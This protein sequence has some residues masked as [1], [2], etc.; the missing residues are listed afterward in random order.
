M[1]FKV[2]NISFAGSE[3][4][5]NI[6]FAICMQKKI[7]LD[8]LF[9]RKDIKLHHNVDD[10]ARKIVYFGYVP[11]SWRS[12]WK[13]YKEYSRVVAPV[14]D[15]S[16]SYRV[17]TWSLTDPL[18]RY[19]INFF[20]VKDIYYFEEGSGSYRKYGPYNYNL[21]IKTFFVSTFIFLS[22]QV[23]SLTIKPLR[24]SWIKGWALFDNCFPDIDI[25]KK[26]IEHKCFQKVVED[27]LE[28]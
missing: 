12:I 9:I 22:T 5:Q 10:Y 15:N 21:G 25:E 7:V 28:K 1:E 14:L 6:L 8:I 27:T 17:M 20:N 18:I 2:K 11:F 13:Y 24:P 23:L 26:I 4:Q 16:E 3:Y 19:T